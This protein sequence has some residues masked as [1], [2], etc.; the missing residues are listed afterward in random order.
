MDDF[1]HQMHDLSRA[2]LL[3]VE[4]ELEHEEDVGDQELIEEAHDKLDQ[5]LKELA[6]R[7]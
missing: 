6:S 3:D 5:V 4:H 2:E 7:G 1:G